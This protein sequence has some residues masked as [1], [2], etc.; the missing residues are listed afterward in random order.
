VRTVDRLAVVAAVLSAVVG[1]LSVGL[2][3]GNVTDRPPAGEATRTPSPTA[4][5]PATVTPSPPVPVQ[6]IEIVVIPGTPPAADAARSGADWAG[7]LA[8]FGAFLA[9]L[10]SLGAIVVALRKVPVPGSA[11]GHAGPA[12]SSGQS[13]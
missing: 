2:Y 7:L 4:S 6:R 12:G 5:P 9:G 1:I 8:A 11:P 3:L 13:A 10:G